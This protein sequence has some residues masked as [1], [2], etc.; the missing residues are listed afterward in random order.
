M[1]LRQTLGVRQTCKHDAAVVKVKWVPGTSNFYRR[2]A[3]R[4]TLQHVRAS[5]EMLAMLPSAASDGVLRQWD[6]RTGQCVRMWTG[7]GDAI[8]DLWVAADG[9]TACTGSEDATARLFSV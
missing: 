4:K 7:H 3:P 2:A 1:L 9:K 5:F 8:L 6:G